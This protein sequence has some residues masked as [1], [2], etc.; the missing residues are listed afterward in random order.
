MIITYD[1]LYSH[2]ISFPNY[3]CEP[4]NTSGAQLFRIKDYHSLVDAAS[5]FKNSKQK[6]FYK[7]IYIEGTRQKRNIVGRIIG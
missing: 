1:S 5:S 3:N 6:F 4:Q 2:D 7:F